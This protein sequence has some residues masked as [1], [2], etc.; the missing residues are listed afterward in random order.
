[1]MAIYGYVVW[2]PLNHFEDEIPPDQGDLFH[3]FQRIL[4]HPFLEGFP[5]MNELTDE[6]AIVE[7]FLNDYVEEPKGQGG[8]C[9]WADLEP[10]VRPVSQK[11]LARV[12]DDQ[13]GAF[14]VGPPET[15]S[16][17]FVRI[18]SQWVAA[19]NHDAFGLTFVVA[20]G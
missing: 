16:F 20:H 3:P 6:L 19:P 1:M 4:F 8:I 18:G 10:W 15:F 2:Y 13:L 12:Y 7:P 5:A 11:P 17:V 9:P 14:F